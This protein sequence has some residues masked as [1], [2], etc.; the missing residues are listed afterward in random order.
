[1]NDK[2][3]FIAPN[4]PWRHHE[5]EVCSTHVCSPL[6]PRLHY[7]PSPPF[8]P[9]LLQTAH[10]LLPLQVN[11]ASGCLLGKAAVEELCLLAVLCFLSELRGGLRHFQLLGFTPGRGGVL[12]IQLS[13][14]VSEPVLPHTS[15][16]QTSGEAVP[17]DTELHKQWP[18]LYFRLI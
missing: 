11:P 6:P 12:C 18:L 4:P 14:S 13:P 5:M 3:V 10:I 17:A 8:P 1:M 15:C 9:F 2:L 7:N 16:S